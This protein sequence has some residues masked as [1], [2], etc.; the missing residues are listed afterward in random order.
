MG[1]KGEDDFCH[2]ACHSNTNKRHAMHAETMKRF[3]RESSL[4]GLF[5]GFQDQFCLRTRRM[6]TWTL[7]F[8]Q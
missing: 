7:K 8:T 2:Y 1:K 3:T 4:F 6:I 5:F